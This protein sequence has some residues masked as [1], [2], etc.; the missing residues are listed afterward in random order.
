[1]RF[2]GILFIVVLAAHYSYIYFRLRSAMGPGWKWTTLYLVLTLL[3][4]F[5][6]RALW[7]VDLGN[8]PEFRKVLSY[9]VYMGLAFFF[10]LFTAFA[11]LD[12]VRL[13]GMAGRYPVLH[14]PERAAPLT[15]GPG[16]GS[17]GLRFSCL[18]LRLV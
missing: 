16:M 3:L 11:A 5:G 17:S 14:G 15:E 10:I 12:L 4:V 13:P 6:S 18:R 2:F 7:Q 8:Y 9:V 1:M